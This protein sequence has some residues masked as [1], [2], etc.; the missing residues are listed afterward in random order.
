MNAYQDGAC[1]ALPNGEWTPWAKPLRLELKLLSLK[2]SKD[3]SKRMVTF[4]WAMEFNGWRASKTETWPEDL[5]PRQIDA[6]V[7]G[8]TNPRSFTSLKLKYLKWA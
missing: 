3:A 5:V 8:Y 2:S 7:I 1:L 6:I 4:S